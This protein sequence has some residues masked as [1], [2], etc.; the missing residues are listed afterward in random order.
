MRERSVLTKWRDLNRANATPDAE[1]AR[2]KALL[3]REHR[4]AVDDADRAAKGLPLGPV[5]AGSDFLQDR[6][7][8]DDKTL[9]PLTGKTAWRHES[10]FQRFIRLSQ[11]VD[12]AACTDPK[13]QGVEV[14]RALDRR[15]AG[16]A[17]VE[18]WDIRERGTK[19]S[20]DL[21]RGGSAASAAGISD[22]QI[23]A[24]NLLRSWERHM[25]RNDW[26][27]VRRVCGENC[28]VAQA[29]SDISPSYRESTLA[30]FREALDGLILAR[31]D[32]RKCEWC[33]RGKPHGASL[34]V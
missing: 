30:R 1:A 22:A 18:A 2:V 20:L 8:L 33:R 21:S 3:G 12:K 6:P 4:L 23:D 19:D 27:I 34:N 26:M 10:Q 9:K 14:E 7:A 29:V 31:S 11:H 24:A 5:V 13:A 25:G 15:D 17:F 32:A 28:A 16:K